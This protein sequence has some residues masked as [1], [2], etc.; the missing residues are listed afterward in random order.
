M[1]EVFHQYTEMGWKVGTQLSS[2]EMLASFCCV[3]NDNE[4]G[5]WTVQHWMLLVVELSTVWAAGEGLT[6]RVSGSIFV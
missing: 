1:D 3:S 5:M 2:K 6:R 4:G